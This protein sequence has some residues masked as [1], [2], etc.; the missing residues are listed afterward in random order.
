[1][2]G[3]DENERAREEAARNMTPE[4]RQ[5]EAKINTE[6][7]T[8][9]TTIKGKPDELAMLKEETFKARLRRAAETEDPHRVIRECVERI[10]EAAREIHA[11]MRGPRVAITLHTSEAGAML[12]GYALKEHGDALGRDMTFGV[13]GVA[14]TLEGR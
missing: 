2:P 4:Q 6:L 9:L 5:L 7:L 10:A 13:R 8:K 1:M 12:L 14:I 3:E 11:A